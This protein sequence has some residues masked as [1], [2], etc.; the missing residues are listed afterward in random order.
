MKNG[1]LT[2]KAAALLLGV[3]VLAPG[4]LGTAQEHPEHPTKAAAKEKPEIT[5]ETL[6]QAITDYINKD[7][8]LKGGYFLVYDSQAQKPLALTLEKVHKDKLAKVG[9]NLYFACTDLKEKGGSTYDLDFFMKGS[10]SGLTV[11]EVTIHKENGNPRYIWYEE[12]GIWKRKETP[13]QQ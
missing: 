6:A 10:N 3:I 4:S 12:S 2:L 9:E 1:G 13:K 11:T 8:D 5:M 7:T